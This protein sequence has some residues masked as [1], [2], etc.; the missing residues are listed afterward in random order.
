MRA[1]D[2]GQHIAPVIAMLDIVTLRK[3]VS[4]AWPEAGYA[5]NRYCK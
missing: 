4:P 5:D 1:V 3:A 2:M